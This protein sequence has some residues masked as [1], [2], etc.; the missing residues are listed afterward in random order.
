MLMLYSF[1]R[2]SVVAKSVVANVVLKWN[3]EVGEGFPVEIGNAQLDCR[4][5]GGEEQKERKELEAEWRREWEK[6]MEARMTEQWRKER[7]TSEE[8]PIREIREGIEVTWRREWDQKIEIEE[9]EKDGVRG[10][11][12]KGQ[13]EEVRPGEDMEKSVGTIYGE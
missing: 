3:A 4:V 13:S 5:G 7:N 11:E 10:G 9:Q 2:S 1:T 12:N 8:R 6:S